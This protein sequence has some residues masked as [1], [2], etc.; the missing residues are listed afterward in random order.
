MTLA[1]SLQR[2]LESLGPAEQLSF[3]KLLEAVYSIRYTGAVTLHLRNGEV[4][5]VDMGAPVR[6]S[7]ME[8]LD[9]KG[10]SPPQ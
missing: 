4:K 9:N 5:Q 10:G 1:P 8:G 2:L 6:L 7:I 3:P